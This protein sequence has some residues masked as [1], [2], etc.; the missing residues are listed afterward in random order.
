MNVFHVMGKL[1][2]FRTQNPL[3]YLVVML[4]SLC[5]V[6]SIAYGQQR[7]FATKTQPIVLKVGDNLPDRIWTEPLSVVNYKQP[8]IILKEDKDKLILLDFWN[9]WCAACIKNFP[10]MEALQKQFGDKIKILAVSTQDRATLEK[11][12]TSKNGQRY[13]EMLSVAGDTLFKD[14]F[15]HKGV[16]YIVWLY[17]GKVLNTTDVEQ[18]GEA[19]IREVLLGGKSSLQTVI[20]MGRDRPLMLSENFDFE[21][22]TQMLHYSLFTKGRMRGAGFG[23]GFHREDGIAYGRQFT[24]RSLMNIYRAIAYELFG[25]CKESFSDKRILNLAKDPASIDPPT[26]EEG[27]TNDALLYSYEYIA[28]VSQADS[29]YEN[30]LRTLNQYAGYTATIE[31]QPVKCLALI[32]T[33]AKDLIHTQGGMSIDNFHRTPSILQN[34]PLSSLVSGLNANLQVTPLPVVDQTGYTGNVD[35]R[36]SGTKDLQLLRNELSR[37]DLDLVEREC[38]LDMLVVRD[39]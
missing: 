18:V 12:F 36:L 17:Q 35:L 6:D 30:M 22:G 10:K 24:N 16:P 31:K 25:E 7:K 27:K 19:T 3:P 11:F 34:T 15:P 39:K 38:H 33:S 14:L 26:N 21:R 4:L 9:T 23:T 37:Y 29:L 20:Q 32:R 8:A 5:G 2:P 13:K 1:C 28:P